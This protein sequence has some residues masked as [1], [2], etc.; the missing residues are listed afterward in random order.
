MSTIRASAPIALAI[1]TICCSGMLSVSTGRSGSMAD[2][3]CSSSAAARRRRACQSTRRHSPP[4]SS[5]SAMFSATRQVR[6][7]R[8]LLVDHRDAERPRRGRVHV[9]DLAP[10]D[11]QR[12]GVGRLGAGQ[13]L[14]EAWTCPRR[15][16]R[17]ARGPRRPGGRTTRRRAPAHRQTTWRRRRRRGGGWTQGPSAHVTSCPAGLRCRPPPPPLPR[18]P[19][20]GLYWSPIFRIA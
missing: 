15:S 17:R 3:T 13:D 6:E 5:A 19:G 20:V 1:S 11:V 14:D 4:G 9:P 16:R 7:Q 8:R 18:R 2:P 10:G 12:A